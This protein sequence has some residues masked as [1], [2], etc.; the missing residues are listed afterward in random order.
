MLVGGAGSAKTTIFQDKLSQLPDE[1]MFFS[2]SMNYL[3]A[4]G[5]LQP[6]LEQPL[7]K[8]TGTMFAPPG[9]KKLI[10]FM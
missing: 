2:I 10:Y 9:T 8:K 7:E 1:L 6:I 5:S 4:A 3:T